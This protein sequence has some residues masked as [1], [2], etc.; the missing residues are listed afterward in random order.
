MKGASQL[1]RGVTYFMR[2]AVELNM[3]WLHT[4]PFLQN[5][6][7]IAGVSQAGA[8]TRPLFSS[9]RAM[10]VTPLRGPLSNR[11][12]ETHAPN[13]SPKICLH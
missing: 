13:V 1:K 6:I 7:M 3:P 12:G 8:H 5:K 11:Q 4:G 9:S 10:L 2:G